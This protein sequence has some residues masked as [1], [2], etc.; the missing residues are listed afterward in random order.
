MAHY[1]GIMT[2]I[3]KKELVKDVYEMVL[4]GES[5]SYVTT[6]GQ[7]INIKINDS[8]QPY[9][10]RPMSICDYD[11]NH[12]TIIFRVV[13]EG[14]KILSEKQ[15]GDQLDCLTGLGNG[16]DDLDYQNAV[17]IGG[18]LGV[19]PMYKLTK[20]L[21]AKGVKVTAILGFNTKDAVFYQKE[22][23]KLCPTFIATMDGSLGDKGTVVDVLKKHE[24]DMDVYYACGPEK[25][26]DALVLECPD[27]GYLSFEARMGCGFGAC[28]GCSCKVKTKPYK[29]ICVEGPVL[30]SSEVIV[31]G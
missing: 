18:G 6:P 20:D 17:V 24:I 26:L 25:M 23:E 29:R 30:H 28:M 11:K 22:F 8:L 4:E 21:L 5:A 1:Q 2:I 16:F 10:R 7:F 15:I 27:K 9:L 12:I 14:T 19:P 3:S 31:N 13:G